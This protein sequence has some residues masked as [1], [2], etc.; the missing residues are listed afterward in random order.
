MPLLYRITSRV[1][2]AWFAAL[3][4]ALFVFACGGGDA[5]GPEPTEAAPEPTVA[6]AEAESELAEPPRNWTVVSD[7]IGA[8]LATPDIAI[9]DRRWAVVLYD[10]SGTVKF[11]VLLTESYFYP[12]GFEGSAPRE[13]PIQEV[14]ARYHAFPLGTRGIY[15][16]PTGVRPRGRLVRRGVGTVAR[17]VAEVG[18]GTLSRFRADRVGGSWTTAAGK[19]EQDG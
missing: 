3:M 14:K 13:G 7:D 18:R 12:E 4:L 17:R 9:G 8:E 6:P 15:V 5:T 10:D 19:H 2:A 16:Y 11:P 1:P